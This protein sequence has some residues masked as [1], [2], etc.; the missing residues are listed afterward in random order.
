MNKT[1]STS[2]SLAFGL[3]H[4][5]FIHLPFLTFLLFFLCS[6]GDQREATD[7]NYIHALESYF[8][9]K[10][11]VKL[12]HGDF[13]V[14]VSDDNQDTLLLF[15]LSKLG[16]V[17][18]VDT[19]EVDERESRYSKR[20]IHVK[21]N[22]FD[23]TDDGCSYYFKDRDS[24]NHRST[25]NYIGFGKAEILQID[26]VSPFELNG[27]QYVR[28]ECEYKVS[29]IPDWARSATLFNAVNIINDHSKLL[30]IVKKYTSNSIIKEQFILELG[31]DGWFV[32]DKTCDL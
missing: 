15:A 22:V 10:F 11:P 8:D 27:K 24:N 14:T 18:L 28:L 4:K 16:L 6:C 26:S 19:T 20:M 29:D 1:N 5:S 3:R 9:R 21:Y 32:R 13:P 23:L 12:L 31:K 30:R 2:Q 7:K 17:K 25:A